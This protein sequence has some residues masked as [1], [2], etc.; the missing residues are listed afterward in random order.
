MVLYLKA[1]SLPRACYTDK[2]IIE[3]SE[4]NASEENL[5]QELHQSKK[6]YQQNLLLSLFDLTAAA[7]QCAELHTTVKDNAAAFNAELLQWIN[8]VENKIAALQTVAEK[9]KLQLN[10]FFE[11]DDLPEED[12]KIQQRFLPLQII[13]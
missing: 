10:K 7:K 9:F 5:K 11:S 2:H 8:D 3:F 6:Q 4:R 13:L 12:S 1:R